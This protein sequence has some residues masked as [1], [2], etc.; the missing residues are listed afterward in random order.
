MHQPRKTLDRAADAAGGSR[1]GGELV[2]EVLH[3]DQDWLLNLSGESQGL[4]GDARSP[5]A[6]LRRALLLYVLQIDRQLRI[7]LIVLLQEI[8]H[9][10]RRKERRIGA[11]SPPS[12]NDVLL[13]QGILQCLR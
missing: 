3:G 2:F 9:L 4:P 12:F 11:V 8:I 1:D 7:A 6:P 5:R 10:F 13:R